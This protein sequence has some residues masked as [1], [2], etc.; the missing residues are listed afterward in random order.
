MHQAVSL[1]SK[2]QV[3]SK[4]N[5]I[6]VARPAALAYRV[7]GG[8]ELASISRLAYQNQPLPIRLPAGLWHLLLA[9][10]RIEDAPYEGR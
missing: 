3:E 4:S 6:E 7:S 5:G 2:K 9:C 8:V 1:A 10:A